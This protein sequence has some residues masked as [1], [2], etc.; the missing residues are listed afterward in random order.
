MVIPLGADGKP[1]PTT[2]YELRGTQPIPEDANPKAVYD[3]PRR[4]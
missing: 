4:R 2:R 1:D 3:R